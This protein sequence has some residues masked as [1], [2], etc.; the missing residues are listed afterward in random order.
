MMILLT[1]LL[2]LWLLISRPL[3]ISGR[4]NKSRD[5]LQLV[6]GWGSKQNFITYITIK[7]TQ[8]QII[9]AKVIH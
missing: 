4:H 3:L 2:M 5:K 8:Q 6:W 1:V 9:N 7:K